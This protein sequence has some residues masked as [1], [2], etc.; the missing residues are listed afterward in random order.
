MADPILGPVVEGDTFKVSLF[1]KLY[2][3]TIMNVLYYE[4]SDPGAGA[5]DAFQVAK[6]L[7]GKMNEAVTGI[8]TQLRALQTLQLTHTFYRCQLLRGIDQ[9]FPFYDEP[10]NEIGEDDEPAKVSNIALSIEKRADFDAGHPRQ[11]IGRMQVGG[12]P[13]D[14]YQAGF[15]TDVY[16]A[17]FDNV[18]DTMASNLTVLTD[19]ILIPVLSRKGGTNWIDNRIFQCTA[20]ET[21]RVM[22][23]RTVGRGE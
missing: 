7:A 3:Q 15:F 12:I 14:K 10:V 17:A 23:R 1:Q 2:N 21:V 4:C 11:G 18:C 22:N 5:P 20:K 9:T 6:A 13:A 8:G 19:V 16:V